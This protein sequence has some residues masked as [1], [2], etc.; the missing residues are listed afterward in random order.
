VLYTSGYSEDILAPHRLLGDD[1]ASIAKPYT[2]EPLTR[3]VRETLDAAA[4][5][6]RP[7]M[8]LTLP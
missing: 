5:I 4:R 8:K 2:L 3:R 6:A 1:I 7:R